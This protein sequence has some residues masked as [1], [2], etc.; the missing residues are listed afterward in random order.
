MSTAIY[1]TLGFIDAGINAVDLG[2]TETPSVKQAMIAV[3]VDNIEDI[4]PI[5]RWE[6]DSAYVS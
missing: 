4:V 1:N 5:S 2:Y 6:Y 3:T